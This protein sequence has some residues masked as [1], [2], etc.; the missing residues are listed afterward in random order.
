MVLEEAGVVHCTGKPTG[1][2]RGTKQYTNFELVAQS[3]D[4]ATVDATW[5]SAIQCVAVERCGAR[6]RRSARERADAHGRRSS[7]TGAHQRGYGRGAA[8]WAQ[9]RDSSGV[10][11][12]RPCFVAALVWMQREL[13]VGSKPSVDGATAGN[14]AASGDGTGAAPAARAQAPSA[15]AAPPAPQSATQLAS[16]TAATSG[17]QPAA[18][19]GAGVPSTASRSS[20]P[21]PTRSSA[22]A[23]RRS[24][25]IIRSRW[26]WRRR[27]EALA[28]FIAECKQGG[29]TAAELETAE[30][31]GF[32]TGLGVDPPARSGV[33]AAPL[34]RQ[35]RAD[36]LWHRRHLRLPG[37]RPAR[38]RFRPQIRPAGHPRRRRLRP[39]RRPSR[40]A[41]RLIRAPAGW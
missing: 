6:G 12:W 35:F 24:R 23:S 14:V 27:N 17:S 1:V 21:G 40:S 36:G 16:P 25:P 4:A 22:R 10:W 41:T 15:G 34:R 2:T 39:R 29:T 28:A 7:E 11:S 30:K 5:L 18:I 19:G 26:R 37:A 3:R 31:K 20:P 9:L 8:A 33:E 13:W 38:P 32:D